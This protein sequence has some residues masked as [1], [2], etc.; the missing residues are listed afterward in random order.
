MGK[1]PL[2]LSGAAA[3]VLFGCAGTPQPDAAL[4]AARSQVAAAA[5]NAD[6]VTYATPQLQTAQGSLG[7]AEV[8][9]SNGDM[10]R[11]DH[12]AFLASRDAETAQEIAQAKKAQQVVAN[13]PLARSQALLENE[14][15]EAQK[16]RAEAAA[17]RSQQGL[18]V[19]PRDIVFKSGSAQL[20]PQATANLQEVARYL[21]NN[22][23][24]K[25]LIEG[26]TDSTGSAAVN[27]QLSQERADAVR[28]ALANDGVDQSRIGIRG[29]GPSAPIAS[30]VNTAG[31]LLNR[32]VAIVISNADGTF[33]ETASGSTTP[34]PLAPVSR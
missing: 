6:V 33:P 11:V 32:R 31:R 19:T 10:A 28:L 12:Y 7:Q 24:R 4:I 20:D 26:F 16:A 30:N 34:P 1:M 29:M 22:P 15:L 2:Y 21:R 27:Q 5:N 3:C 13:A 8:A 17:A 23:D 14:R 25:V 9:L 18:V